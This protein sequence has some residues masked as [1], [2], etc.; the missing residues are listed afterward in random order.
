MISYLK[1][2]FFFNKILVVKISVAL[3]KLLL[4]ALKCYNNRF[5]LN[6]V[7][8]VNILHINYF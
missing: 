8:K 6:S 7:F 2:Y 4:I 3:P 1:I 5:L